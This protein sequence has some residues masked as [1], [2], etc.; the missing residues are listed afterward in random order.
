MNISKYDNSRTILADRFSEIIDSTPAIAPLIG[1]NIENLPKILE[2]FAYDISA[3][4]VILPKETIN[5]LK[6]ISIMLPGLQKKIPELYFKNE[7][8]KFA[9]FYFQGNT[10]QAK[11]ALACLEQNFDISC[12]L[13]LVM[14][15]KGFKVLEI[16]AGSSLGGWQF[17]NFEEAIRSCHP[18]LAKQVKNKQ[19]SFRSFQYSYIAFLIRKITEH[20][21]HTHEDINIFIV[22]KRAPI[23]TENPLFNM[24]LNG[25]L[26]LSEKKGN[27]YVG[28]VKAL[29]MQDGQLCAEGK[30][31]IH[32]VL[33][34]NFGEE[35]MS[36]DLL[37][38]VLTKK[39]YFPDHI[40]SRVMRDKRNLVILRTLAT[41]NMF[42]E[43]ENKL[44]LDIIPWTAI[45]E[46]GYV[47]Y[48][49]NN[50]DLY[51]LL[52]AKKDAF[53]IKPANGFKGDDVYVGKSLTLE[54][55]K[56]VVSTS[57]QTKSF[58]AQEYCES[59]SFLA[60]NKANQWVD[61][62]LIWGAFGFGDSYGGVFARMA[63]PKKVKGVINGATG[64]ISALVYEA[65]A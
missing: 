40:G 18:A 60:P 30:T 9:D 55:W 12:R 47:D 2:E 23:V 24:L 41:A 25:Y 36:S 3:W 28:N 57:I 8:Q 63:E 62:Q 56:K 52:C 44:I 10:A 61:H 11:S 59:L 65:N 21:L 29:K 51:T 45:L 16:N 58:I 33:M 50:C 6:Q 34:M 1:R 54:E 4:P 49:G 5:K 39:V 7:P 31:P 22:D 17:E 35:E 43:K 13:D 37:E 19:L 26:A 42:S 64:A 20:V 14:T 46:E 27:A 15:D 38:A 32:G 53:V 48:Q